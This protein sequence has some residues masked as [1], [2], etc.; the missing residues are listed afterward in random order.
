[1]AELS[2][3]FCTEFEK[4]LKDGKNLPP[5][6][7][8]DLCM[9]VIWKYKHAYKFT[10]PCEAFLTHPENRSRLMLSARNAHKLA[11]QIHLSGADYAQLGNALCFEIAID[12]K[13]R[14]L[15]LDKNSALIKRAGGLLA[16]IN[17]AERFI[18]VGC[19]HTAGICK[20][21]EAGG[22][23]SSK[24]LQDPNGYMDVAKLKKTQHSKKC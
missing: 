15:Q 7:A 5:K 9:E 23:T 1:M 17:G 11:E 10:G 2:E 16:E 3:Q 22:R 8:L 4:A 12:A 6:A 18:T 24:I 21:A 20:H 13:K 19:G 14:Q